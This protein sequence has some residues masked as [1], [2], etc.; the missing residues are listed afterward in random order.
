MDHTEIRMKTNSVQHDQPNT[1]RFLDGLNN[2]L[3]YIPYFVSVAMFVL[4]S[5]GSFA[6]KYDTLEDARDG[7]FY[8]TVKIGDQTW[9][10]ENLN[11][12]PKRGSWC[13]GYEKANCS[14][15]GRLYNWDVIYKVCPS[16]WHASNQTDWQKLVY[17][18]GGPDSAAQH[19]KLKTSMWR[20]QNPRDDN[21][22]GFSALPAGKMDFNYAYQSF[23]YYSYFWL[24]NTS[25]EFG[26]CTLISCTSSD[27]QFTLL[28]P[29]CALS[30]RCVK[31]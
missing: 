6:Q 22:S 13:Y 29:D 24:A 8:L 30:V 7:R 18:L 17:Y 9:M 14:K 31:D 23:G 21:S 5:N 27:V 12:K 4:I 20:N 16:G 11:Y 19:L 10:A 1:S 15:Y 28:H 2:L 3:S 25:G 26:W